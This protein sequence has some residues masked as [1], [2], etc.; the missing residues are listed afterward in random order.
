M[1]PILSFT[2]WFLFVNFNLVF[3]GH[4]MDFSDLLNWHSPKS[5]QRADGG[6]ST[7]S[8]GMLSGS[9]FEPNSAMVSQLP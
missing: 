5:W 9:A 3:I 1:H 4:H 7:L 6:K 8:C 2:G